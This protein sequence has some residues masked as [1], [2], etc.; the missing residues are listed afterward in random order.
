MQT[1]TCLRIY[2]SESTSIQHTPALEAMLEL[3]QE[4]GLRGLSVLRGVE[5]LGKHGIHSA[6]FL[7][8]SASLPLIIEIIDTEKKIQQALPLIQK[9][10]PSS[11]IATWPIQ[12]IQT[13][14]E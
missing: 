4:A 12:L 6:S 2:L 3:C 10:L 14:T 8:L 1:G 9:K 11:L 5:G 7:E 13:S